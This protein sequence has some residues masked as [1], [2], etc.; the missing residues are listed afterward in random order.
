[1]DTKRVP[2]LGGKAR[3]KKLSKEK[4]QEIARSGGKALWAKLRALQDQAPPH[5][6]DRKSG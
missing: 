3:A 1:M 6:A 4:R 2:S 5:R